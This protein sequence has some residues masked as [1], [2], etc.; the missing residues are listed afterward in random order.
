MALAQ[1][2]TYCVIIITSCFH[3]YRFRLVVLLII[4]TLN[5]RV[6]NTHNNFGCVS[7]AMNG[8]LSSWQKDIKHTLS[9]KK[10][11]HNIYLPPNYWVQ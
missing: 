11:S 8:K 2:P 5:G 4:E 7:M 9:F 10:A 6:V 3:Y 1:V